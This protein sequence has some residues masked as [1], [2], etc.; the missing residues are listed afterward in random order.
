[1]EMV[2]AYTAAQ[3]HAVYFLDSSGRLIGE[4]RQVAHGQAAEPPAYIAPEGRIFTTWSRDTSQILEDV[5]CVALTK[6]LSPEEVTRRCRVHVIDMRET[7]SS[8]LNYGSLL[9][10]GKW[11]MGE[12][13]NREDLACLHLRHTGKLRPFRLQIHCDAVLVLTDMGVRAF[14]RGMR[15]LEIMELVP[16]AETAPTETQ[17]QPRYYEAVQKG[18]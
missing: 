11:A 1:M 2:A 9:P 12:V 4:P 13:I 3:T 6:V 8:S 14:D 18:A 17:A 5:Y 15:P 7:V 10:L 16:P